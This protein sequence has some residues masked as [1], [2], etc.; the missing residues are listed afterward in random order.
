MTPR[1]SELTV[2]EPFLETLWGPIVLAAMAADLNFWVYASI[3]TNEGDAAGIA[4]FLA[5]A[6]YA[7]VHPRA[8]RSAAMRIAAVGAVA[9]AAAMA[10][11]EWDGALDYGY[12]PPYLLFVLG[13][14]AGRGFARLRRRS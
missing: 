11:R 4:F 12:L 14:L 10:L 6:V 5:F 1:D 3:G 8:R 2:A 9:A 13:V 7:F